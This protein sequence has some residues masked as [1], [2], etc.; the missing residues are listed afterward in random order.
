MNR[1]HSMHF[2]LSYGRVWAGGFC[3]AA[4]TD[5]WLISFSLK[6]LLVTKSL[7][8]RSRL[9]FNVTDFYA[10]LSIYGCALIYASVIV[11]GTSEK[12]SR[13]VLG[14]SPPSFTHLEKNRIRLFLYCFLTF[15]P[16]WLNMYIDSIVLLGLGRL[17]NDIFID[18]IDPLNSIATILAS[19]ALIYFMSSLVR[20]N[21]PLI[22]SLLNCGC[23][24]K[25][26][27]VVIATTTANA[28]TECR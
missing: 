13:V 25:K 17:F 10:K 18:L 15:L 9:H 19:S 12:C 7:V 22:P 28:G 26:E 5:W 1:G 3:I 8:T 11:R 27:R 23:S 21:T 6:S 24:K 16:M 4:V 2:P 14:L 20:E